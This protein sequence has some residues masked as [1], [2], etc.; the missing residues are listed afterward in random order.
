MHA[1][2]P[3]FSSSRFPT[4]FSR[5][6]PP[7]WACSQPLAPLHPQ[8]QRYESH[9]WS[10]GKQVYLGG[11]GLEVQAATA[12]DLAACRFRGLDAQTNF[13]MSRY[14][15]ELADE[16]TS[17]EE[18]VQTLR[19]QSKAMNLVVSEPNVTM[20]PWEMAISAHVHPEKVRIGVYADE[21][22]AAAAIDT[23][24]V[25]RLG[26]D[27][28]T[29]FPLSDY[30]HVLSPEALET[31]I[32][33]G[34]LQGDPE[35]LAARARE[36]AVATDR[37]CL[38]GHF[39]GPTYDIEARRGAPMDVTSE[40]A[41][42]VGTAATAF[43]GLDV[44]S[45]IVKES[46]MAM[47]ASAG[48]SAFA[49]PQRQHPSARV[50]DSWMDAEAAASS[51]V[52][53]WAPPTT[54]D[55]VRFSYDRTGSLSAV[56]PPELA[57]E[58]SFR[59]LPPG[60]ASGAFPGAL[61]PP[62][63]AYPTPHPSPSGAVPRRRSLHAPVAT[64]IHVERCMPAGAA[65]QAGSLS[66]DWP[67]TPRADDAVRETPPR[68]NVTCRTS[69]TPRSVFDFVDGARPLTGKREKAEGEDTLERSVS[70]SHGG[71]DAKRARME[72]E[73]MADELDAWLRAVP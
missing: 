61:P 3:S 22:A 1:S 42:S 12:Y 72:S 56:R 10:E 16:E 64:S 65:V 4:N 29:V 68:G 49:S 26:L 70:A 36:R 13:C 6:L 47:P 34:S 18:V 63:S 69:N 58:A 40:P 19:S 62:A 44:A 55:S 46:G 11:F 28:P 23:A 66:F 27:A 57:I 9:V 15:A 71:R 24:M 25:Q 48:G 17:R 2:R 45:H 73:P 7:L 43:G 60:T 41:W 33:T 20:E 35:T 8:P 14:A 59:S 31:A 54:Q 30:A 5:A 67:A 37:D 50:V 53:P 32:A 51:P 21:R 52:A 38:T 39:Y